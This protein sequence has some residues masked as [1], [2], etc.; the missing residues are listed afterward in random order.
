M[1]APANEAF[2]YSQHSALPILEVPMPSPANY[3]SLQ[4]PKSCSDSLPLVLHWSFI[5]HL[6]WACEPQVCCVLPLTWWTYIT[7]RSLRAWRHTLKILYLGYLS[8][9]QLIIYLIHTLFKRGVCVCKYVQLHSFHFF[10]PCSHLPLY[11]WTT[12]HIPPL[13]Y[14]PPKLTSHPYILPFPLKKEHHTWGYQ[15]NKAYDILIKIG[16]NPHFK[17]RKANN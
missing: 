9:L 14:S 15:M 10:L 2:W 8:L 6:H 17:P 11:I 3:I 1:L 12:V 16:T 4:S 5:V 13:L 7:L